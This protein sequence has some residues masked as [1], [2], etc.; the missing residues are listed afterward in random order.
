MLQD[1]C[2]VNGGVYDLWLADDY[3]T[4]PNG[5]SDGKGNGTRPPIPSNWTTKFLRKTPEECAQYL[6]NMPQSHHGVDYRKFAIIDS[7]IKT[8]QL[9]LCRW[10][11]EEEAAKD[12]QWKQELYESEL[13][14]DMDEEE[15]EQLE[16]DYFADCIEPG[17]T[18]MPIVHDAAAPYLGT[19]AINQW[20][21]DLLDGV[22]DFN[23]TREK[24]GEQWYE[25]AE[26]QSEMG[27]MPVRPK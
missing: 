17:V 10:W 14:D 20:R 12:R 25:N 26:R 21:E 24:N 23:G 18:S 5:S 22:G 8:G 2:D 1:N 16:S 27:S 11:T 19:R 13:E 6:E 7:R 15:R 9:T 3:D 4:L